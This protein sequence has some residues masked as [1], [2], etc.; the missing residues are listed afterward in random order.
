MALRSVRGYSAPEVEQR[1]ARARVLCTVCGD[2]N[3]KFSVEW[4]LFQCTF[5]KGDIDGARAFAADLLE[6]AA[7][8]PGELLIDA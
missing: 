8:E 3:D 6:H 1:L 7:P 5:V 2:V 4:G